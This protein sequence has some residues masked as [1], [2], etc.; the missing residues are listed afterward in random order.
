MNP[1]NFFD[2]LTIAAHVVWPTDE[3]ILILANNKVGVVHNPTSNMKLSSGI[4]PISKMLE[5][6]VLIG[7]GTDGAASNNDLDMWEEMRLAALLQKVSTMNP[8]ALPAIEVL[9][10]ATVNGAKIIGMDNAIGKIGIGMTADIIQ[11]GYD[12]V[13]HLPSYDIASH[14]VY[15]TDEQD[16]INVIIDGKLVMH[17]K[18]L[19]TIDTKEIEDDVLYFADKIK[20][21]IENN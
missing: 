15:V 12:D 4:A 16:V 10:M 6:G 7:I 3:E 8:E 20:K 18:E 13:H 19:L 2:G 21:S 14:L 1:I 17:E 11:I 9:K 5:A